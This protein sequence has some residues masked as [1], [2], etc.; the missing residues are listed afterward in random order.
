MSSYLLDTDAVIDYLIGIPATV[1]LIQGLHA[2]GE[3]LGVC[4]VV[5]AEVYSGLRPR[6]HTK[7]HPL[8]SALQFLPTSPE[9]AQQAGRWRYAYVRRGRPLATTDVLVAATAAEH[10]ATIVTGNRADYPMPE[11]SV[12]P[13]PRVRG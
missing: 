1:S 10:G 5:L 13:L 3:V 8:L 9:A 7:A 6:D 2:D 4:A 12:L 11:L